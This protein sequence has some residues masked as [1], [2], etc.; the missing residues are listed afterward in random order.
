ME[1]ANTVSRREQDDVLHY[2]KKQTKFNTKAQTLCYKGDERTEEFTSITNTKYSTATIHKLSLLLKRRMMHTWLLKIFIAGLV[3]LS[4][5]QPHNTI[6]SKIEVAGL[7]SKIR[8][9]DNSYS[10]DIVVHEFKGKKLYRQSVCSIGGR[11]TEEAFDPEAV[12]YSQC[13]T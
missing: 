11:G 9:D 5:A 6:V 12:V 4:I 10:F 3:T 1:G 8:L 2:Q 13:F 7:M